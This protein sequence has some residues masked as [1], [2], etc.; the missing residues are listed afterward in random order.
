[1][2]SQKKRIILVVCIL[3]LFVSISYLH[4][5]KITIK[6]KGRIHA[7]IYPD[8]TWEDIICDGSSNDECTW[9][10]HL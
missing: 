6:G 10:L 9:I 5:D 4:S 2:K 3:L 8:G 7:V 1:M